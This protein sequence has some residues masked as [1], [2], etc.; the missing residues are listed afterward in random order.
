MCIRDRAENIQRAD[1][2]PIEE[3]QAYQQL[4]AAGHTQVEIA[5]R[6]GKSQSVIAHK[7]RLLK[8]PGAI[9]EMIADGRLTEAHARQILRIDYPGMCCQQSMVMLATKA[10]GANW[11][12]KRL[13]LEVDYQQATADGYW[14]LPI[15]DRLTYK[16]L[17]EL[18]ETVFGPDARYADAAYQAMLEKRIEMI[19][20]LVI[21]LDDA[22]GGALGLLLV[23]EMPLSTVYWYTKQAAEW[24]RLYAQDVGLVAYLRY[25]LCDGTAAKERLHSM[26]KTL[27]LDAGYGA[28]YHAGMVEIIR[29]V[30][31]D[32]A[33]LVGD[34]TVAEMLAA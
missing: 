30:D 3:A 33:E 12:V 10:A 28:A 20:K 22:G 24:Q 16:T 29:G 27:P 15:D 31:R 23:E 25:A 1:L 13:Q 14:L 4:L 2:T 5:R 6:I 34:E 21:R 19:V 32:F 11:S 18:N 9:Q 26:L 17:L 7:L 8:I